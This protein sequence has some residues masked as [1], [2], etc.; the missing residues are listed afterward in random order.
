MCPESDVTQFSVLEGVVY[1]FIEEFLLDVETV[2]AQDGQQLG[3][4]QICQ[5]LFANWTHLAE[6]LEVVV[7]SPALRE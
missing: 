4:G 6:L 5:G 3:Q 7:S 1:C 2:Q